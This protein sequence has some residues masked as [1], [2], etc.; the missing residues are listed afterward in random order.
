MKRIN[1]SI[2]LAMAVVIP[3]STCDTD[4]FRDLNIDPNALSEIN[5]NYLFTAAELSAGG[6]KYYQ[7][8]N[9]EYCAYWMQHL[10]WFRPGDKY[11]MCYRTAA[12]LYGWLLMP[13]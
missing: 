6:N 8:T 5:M 10:A 4:E 11:F 1:K 2:L 3:M 12:A 7:W 9:I 13:A